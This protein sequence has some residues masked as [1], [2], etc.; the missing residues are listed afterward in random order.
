MKFKPKD[1]KIKE[2]VRITYVIPA[3]LGWECISGQAKERTVYWSRP[4]L[5]TKR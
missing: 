5:Q 3:S 4:T 2:V 1:A